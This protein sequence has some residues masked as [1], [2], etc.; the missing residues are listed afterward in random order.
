MKYFTWPE[1]MLIFF[2]VFLVSTSFISTVTY[3]FPWGVKLGHLFEIFLNVGVYY[4]QLS[5]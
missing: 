1:K 3:L 4:S 5:S 2:I